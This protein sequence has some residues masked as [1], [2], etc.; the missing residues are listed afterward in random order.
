MPD[1][2]INALHNLENF[3]D[4]YDDEATVVVLEAMANAIDAKATRVDITLRNRHIAF[5]DDGPGMSKKT[6]KDYHK[7]SNSTKSKGQGIGFAGVGAKIYLAV[8]N[9]TTILTETYG[10]D[11]PFASDMYVRHKKPQWDNANTATSIMSHGTLYSV[12][13]R[14]NH[15][16]TL[17]KKLPDILR[18]TFN[19]AM[20]DGLK[21]YVNDIRLE[22]WNPP[23]QHQ[24]EGTAKARRLAF[25]VTL[26]ITKEDVPTKYRHI[27][28]QVWGKT[29]NTKKLEW[30]GEIPEQ[31]RSRIHVLVDAEKCSKYLKLNKGSFKSGQG[32]VADM[33][34][35][36]ERWVHGTLRKRG[37][38]A[39]RP[40]HIKRN[41]KLSKFLQTVF[42]KPEYE[43]LNPDAASGDGPGKGVGRG[44]ANTSI[45]TFIEP[46]AKKPAQSKTTSRTRRGGGGLRIQPVDY[47]DDPRDGWLDPETSNFVCNCSHPLYVK[48]ERNEEARNLRVKSVMFSALLR[49]GA[50]KH[51]KTIAEVLDAHRDLMTAA[52]DVK[53]V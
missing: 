34:K 23:H 26:T 21:V 20:R 41:A 10:P 24:I 3:L 37:L 17:E 46:A 8:W 42:K 47:P 40:A 52:K 53:V 36:V 2:E 11:G 39:E 9:G 18:D 22:P 12:K 32:P 35:C 7:I 5:R 14:E 29:I 1:I 51:Q 28:Y 49:N 38:V 45:K 19:T 16:K 48:Y 25:P 6:F 27:Q 50:Q 33:Y 44:G 4:A 30:A 43:W 13:L 31:Y 15:Y